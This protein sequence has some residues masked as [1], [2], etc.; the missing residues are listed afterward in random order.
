V[1]EKTSG[2]AR[3]REGLLA[4]RHRNMLITLQ[5]DY[6]PVMCVCCGEHTHT[7]RDGQLMDVSDEL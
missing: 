3:K 5:Q 4:A 1:T 6:A 2:R 7:G